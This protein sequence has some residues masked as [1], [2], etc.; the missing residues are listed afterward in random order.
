M[1][2][3]VGHKF[4]LMIILSTFYSL[5]VQGSTLSK[6]VGPLSPIEELVGAGEPEN[7]DFGLAIVQKLPCRSGEGQQEA[8]NDFKAC[9]SL[10]PGICPAGTHQYTGGNVAKYPPYAY[11]IVCVCY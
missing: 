9:Q 8:I 5:N 3:N 10:C 4:Y 6:K 11:L 1:R 7:S 2:I